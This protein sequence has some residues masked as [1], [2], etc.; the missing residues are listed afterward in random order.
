MDPGAAT[1]PSKAQAYS[2]AHNAPVPNPQ[3]TYK[4][5]PT[6]VVNEGTR[7]T[8]EY[9]PIE[10]HGYIIRWWMEYVHKS[11]VR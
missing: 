9:E 6:N 5:L 10:Q 4:Q 1:L 2:A 8:V 3:I 11:D 7:V